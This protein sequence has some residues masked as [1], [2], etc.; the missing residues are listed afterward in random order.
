MNKKNVLCGLCKNEFKTARKDISRIRC[1]VC[2]QNKNLE[3]EE[4]D[5]ITIIVR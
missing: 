1:P 4:K 3:I 2:N 5:K